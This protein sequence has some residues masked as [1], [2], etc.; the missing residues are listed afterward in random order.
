MNSVSP[1]PAIG[2]QTALNLASRQHL[3]SLTLPS[4]LG[5]PRWLSGK[6]SAC[7]P[8]QETQ[9][10][11]LGQEDTMEK[12]MATQSSILAR[13]FHGHKSVVG[14]SPIRLQRTGQDLVTEP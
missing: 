3:A 10:R 13:K 2:S 12:E 9:V 4:S 14:Y 5:V 8:V 7:L 11:S 6:E 1:A